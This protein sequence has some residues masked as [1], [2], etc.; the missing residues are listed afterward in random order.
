MTFF[1][2][3][4][5]LILVLITLTLISGG[6]YYFWK[7]DFLSQPEPGQKEEGATPAPTIGTIEGSLSF[8]SEGIPSDLTICAEDISTKK[9]YCTKEHLQDEKY[10]FRV[11]YKIEAPTGDYLVFAYLPEDPADRAYYSEFVTCGLS[12]DCPS[13]EPIVV[14]VAAGQTASDIDPQDWYNF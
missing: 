6:V 14:G 2:G 13:H 5:A 12:V 10:M 7:S 9:Q 8:P 11:G 1:K 4:K 3:P